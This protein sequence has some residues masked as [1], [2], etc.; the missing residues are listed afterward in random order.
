[1]LARADRRDRNRPLY[2]AAAPARSRGGVTA[3]A[4]SALLDFRRPDLEARPLA[5][6]SQRHQV[7]AQRHGMVETGKLARPGQA[8]ALAA[9]RFGGGKRRVREDAEAADFLAPSG[10]PGID[11]DLDGAAV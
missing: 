7:H 5:G 8:K 2:G 1:P 6:A 11:D 10:G 9:R 3:G 4:T